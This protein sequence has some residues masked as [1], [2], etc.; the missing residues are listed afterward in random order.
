M[1]ASSDDK[2]MQWKALKSFD[3]E[4][5]CDK[6]WKTENPPQNAA[7]WFSVSSEVDRGVQMW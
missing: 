5:K 1:V 2:K 6:N 7:C 3:M 4:G